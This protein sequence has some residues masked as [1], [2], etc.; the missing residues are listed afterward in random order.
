MI[1]AVL[2]VLDRIDWK[3]RTLRYSI[4]GRPRL[5]AK[6]EAVIDKKINENK[7]SNVV[8]NNRVVGAEVAAKC[9]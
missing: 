5:I 2:A 3:I 9:S 4:A 6:N 8:I 1:L 7:K